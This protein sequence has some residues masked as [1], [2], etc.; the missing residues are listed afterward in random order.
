M[1]FTQMQK[2]ALLYYC[3]DS[4]TRSGGVAHGFSTK[5]GG[6][7]QGALAGLNLG[8]SRGDDPALVAENHRRFSQ[9]IGTNP[10]QMVFCRQ[11]HSDIVKVVTE[12]DALTHLYDANNLEADALVTNCPNLTLAVFYADC[13]PILLYDPKQKVIGAVHSGWRGTSMGIVQ[14]AVAA[15]QT[16]FGSDPAYILAAI[17]PGICAN[18]FETHQDVPTAMEAYLGRDLIAPFVAELG[19]GK[20]AVDLK[21]IL[22]Q[23]LLSQGL[24]SQH[25]SLSPLCTAC[26]LEEFWSHRKLGDQRGNQAAM[27]QLLPE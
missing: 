17:G 15:M 8:R 27:I 3:A 5:L 12:K 1:S 11:I 16:Q 10:D 26:H 23:Q 25:I 18:C 21:G 19:A 13:I 4:F 24:S 22:V 14:K 9:A 20:Y 7:S 6:V 2:E